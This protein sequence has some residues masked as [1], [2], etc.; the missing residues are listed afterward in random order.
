MA[1]YFEGKQHVDII[2]PHKE[3]GI[4][5]L[6]AHPGLPNGTASLG[7]IHSFARGKIFLVLMIFLE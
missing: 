7:K 1:E 4:A 5:M 6:I 2:R 3:H